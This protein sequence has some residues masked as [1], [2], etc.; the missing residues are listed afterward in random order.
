M[1]AAPL[2]TLSTA[3]L[4]R[5]SLLIGLMAV[6]TAGNLLSALAPGFGWLLAARVVT[7]L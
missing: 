7:S 6:F 1:L 2:M 4:G 5:K 3:K